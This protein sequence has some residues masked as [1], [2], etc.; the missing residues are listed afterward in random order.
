MPI[1]TH[2]VAAAHETDNRVG[3][4]PPGGFG[5]TEAFHDEPFQISTNGEGFSTLDPLPT[6][7]QN[8]AERQSTAFRFGSEPAGAGS[9]SHEEPLQASASATFGSCRGKLEPTATQLR[10]EEH[11]TAVG[12]KVSS[13]LKPPN[14]HVDPF[15]R[16]KVAGSPASEEV[17]AL[18]MQNRDETHAIAPI[19]FVPAPTGLTVFSIDQLVPF[20]PSPSTATND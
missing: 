20:Q 17:K 3:K 4:D 9:I 6:A 8:V 7:M 12:E 15:Q 19:E 10:A 18:A 1:A 13:D 5:N 2:V 14:A 11:E 16:S